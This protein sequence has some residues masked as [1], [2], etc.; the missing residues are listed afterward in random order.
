MKA[1]QIVPGAIGLPPQTTRMVR[2]RVMQADIIVR[3]FGLSPL[4]FSCQI[5]RPCLATF[6]LLKFRPSLTIFLQSYGSLSRVIILSSQLVVLQS[7]EVGYDNI[8][9]LQWQ[10]RTGQVRFLVVAFSLLDLSSAFF[11]RRATTA[12][13]IF[14][15]VLSVA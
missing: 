4:D 1:K 3:A 9:A 8:R 10:P 2:A 12:W 15:S 14:L 6:F 11:L 13:P 7:I 5:F